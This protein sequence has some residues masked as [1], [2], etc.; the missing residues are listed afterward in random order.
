MLT[1][2]FIQ[3][4]ICRPDR[5]E[6]VVR[7]MGKSEWT[8]DIARDIV[9]QEF[10][11]S[12]EGQGGRIDVLATLNG[13]TN[14]LIVEVKAGAVGDAEVEQLDWYLTYWRALTK[15]DERLANVREVTGAVLA[16]RFL[17][18]STR[19]HGKDISFVEF[20]LAA[21]KWPFTVVTP[22]IAESSPTQ[23]GTVF[24][25]S[26]LVTLAEHRDYLSTEELRTAFD[27]IAACLLQE[28]D[29]RL[30]WVLCNPKGEHVAIHYK[31]QYIIWVFVHKHS[32]DVGYGTV[33]EQS[34]SLRVTEELPVL[35]VEMEADVHAIVEKIDRQMESDIPP[36]FN[37]R[38]L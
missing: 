25:H 24:K 38:S 31:G 9:N 21:D 27:R 36:N 17:P 23:E 14:L 32:F 13:L 33:G 8:F 5:I 4:A 3:D 20:K 6:R 37:W 28:D 29:Q 12:A 30:D 15:A 18:I 35:P 22:K 1:E 7:Q 10:N 16:E 11:F 34:I 2:Q 19:W 26:R